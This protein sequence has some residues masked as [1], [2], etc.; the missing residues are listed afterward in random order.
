MTFSCF[1]NQIAPSSPSPTPSPAVPLLPTP[2]PSSSVSPRSDSP[3]ATASASLL[4]NYL[5]APPQ[6]SPGSAAG[7]LPA[8]SQPC[9]RCQVKSHVCQGNNSSSFHLPL[10]LSSLHPASQNPKVTLS[11][12][13]SDPSPPYYHSTLPLCLNPTAPVQALLLPKGLTV[14]AH[15]VPPNFNPSS[16]EL[17]KQAF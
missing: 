1:L 4:C 16:K 14:A 7:A 5:P 17:P 2:L 10:S 9:S 15:Q 3:G 6:S 8:A 11:S 13:T 12:L